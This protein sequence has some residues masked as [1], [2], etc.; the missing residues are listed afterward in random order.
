VSRLEEILLDEVGNL[1]LGP[2]AG[3]HPVRLEE[4]ERKDP[5]ERLGLAVP[6][7]HLLEVSGLGLVVV[8]NVPALEGLEHDVL[9]G[10][11]GTFLLVQDVG[12]VHHTRT[13]GGRCDHYQPSRSA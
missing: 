11:G 13:I 7:E 1:G 3:D 2:F 9:I 8:E 5:V 12:N 10:E 6:V 4:G